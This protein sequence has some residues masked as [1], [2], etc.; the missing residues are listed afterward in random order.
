V[1][2]DYYDWVAVNDGH[3]VVGLGD[4]SGKGVAAAMLMSHLRAS[5]HAETR[6]GTSP[7]VIAQAMH[8]SLFRAIESGRFATF[9]LATFETA[10]TG[11]LRFC[12]AGHNPGLLYSAGKLED[13]EATGMPLGIFEEATYTEQTRFF[14]P[15]DV[16]VLY[17]DGISECQRKD[18]MY[19]EDR[20]RELVVRLCA[21]G[22]GAADMARAILED[23]RIFARGPACDD[24]VTLVVVRRL[25]TPAPTAG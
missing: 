8:A 21:Q 3:L 5:L 7:A 18:E 17:S 2:G 11:G 25:A 4:V 1:G 16:L 15:G 20:L 14:A 24:D 9:F 19:G 23:L 22:L 6:D 12:N 10:V 13:L